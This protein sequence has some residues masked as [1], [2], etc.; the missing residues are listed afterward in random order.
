MTLVIAWPVELLDLPQ[1]V[2]CGG[3][4]WLQ[5]SLWFHVSNCQC[6]VNPHCFGT[7]CCLVNRV[8]AV[9]PD[10]APLLVPGRSVKKC[11]IWMWLGMPWAGFHLGCCWVLPPGQECCVE[12]C[13]HIQLWSWKW[14]PTSSSR[15][16]WWTPAW[17]PTRS[18]PGRPEVRTVPWQRTGTAG[19]VRTLECSGVQSTPMSVTPKSDV[20]IASRR[21]SAALEEL[22][23]PIPLSPG[24]CFLSRWD[25]RLQTV[26][27]LLK[28]CNRA[29][30]PP[31]R[32][33]WG[34][35]ARTCTCSVSGWNGAETP[36]R[37][38]PH[39]LFPA[40]RCWSTSGSTHP[41]RGNTC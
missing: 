3:A 14:R 24:S 36:G 28:W 31:H 12:P 6:L 25:G 9:R 41:D 26:S 2:I 37:T 18:R 30:W 16:Y 20:L 11:E 34:V 4:H 19:A 10:S 29:G 35:C 13:H 32:W 22:A 33:C 17:R 8:C 15:G 38:S 5:W 27:P 40:Q 23:G 1:L 21:R 39:T 7:W